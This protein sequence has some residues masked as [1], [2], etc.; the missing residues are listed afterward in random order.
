MGKNIFQWNFVRNFRFKMPSTKCWPY[1]RGFS[2]LEYVFVWFRLWWAVPTGCDEQ[3]PSGCDY[4]PPSSSDEQR[5]SGDEQRISVDE[6]RISGDEQRI[7]G[8]EQRNSGRGEQL[9]SS[10]YSYLILEAFIE[11]TIDVPVT[12]YTRANYLAPSKWETVL[13]CDDVSRWL[14]ASL[15]SALYTHHIANIH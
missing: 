9:R 14:G 11:V 7:S 13:F 6:Q 2:V 1:C 3:Y 8:C 15:E 4:Q 10:C 5:I 12:I